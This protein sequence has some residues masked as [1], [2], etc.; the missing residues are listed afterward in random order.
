M[1]RLTPGNQWLP[2][3]PSP[4]R[5]PHSTCETFALRSGHPR[6]GHRSPDV[7]RNQHT[8]GLPVPPP[9]CFLAP[10]TCTLCEPQPS[11]QQTGCVAHLVP[12]SRN[13]HIGHSSGYLVGGH[14]LTCASHFLKEE[15]SRALL[16]SVGLSKPCLFLTVEWHHRVSVPPH[17]YK[18]GHTGTG[19]SP[20][21][22]NSSYQRGVRIT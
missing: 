5:F 9:S 4:V 14:H 3:D 13:F 17:Q 11:H 22:K 16:G 15:Q 12:R 10:K 2:R 19:G 20:K 18:C 1:T 21:L 6:W 8:H 7:Q